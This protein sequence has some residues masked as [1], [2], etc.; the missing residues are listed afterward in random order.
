MQYEARKTGQTW[1]QLLK[2]DILEPTGWSNVEQFETLYITKEE[3]CNRAVNSVL[4]KKDT[5]TRRD[6]AKH[7]NKL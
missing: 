6:A 7:L 2:V 4:V 1:S 3:F 5:S